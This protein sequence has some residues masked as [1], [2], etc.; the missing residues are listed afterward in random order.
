MCCPSVWLRAAVSLDGPQKTE[1]QMVSAHTGHPRMT[2]SRRQYVLTGMGRFR[3]FMKGI[4][5]DGVLLGRHPVCAF[6]IACAWVLALS[7]ALFPVQGKA[8][9]TDENAVT[10]AEDVFGTTVGHESIGIYD[11]TNVRGFSPK[12]AGNYRIDGLYFDS[13]GGLSSRVNDSET[14]HVGPSAQGYDFPAPTALLQ[15]FGRAKVFRL[16]SAISLCRCRSCA[17]SDA[18]RP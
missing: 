15:E 17:R 6:R 3:P 9:R 13:Q 1:Y 4:D 16:M 14:I 10:S 8:Q 7:S 12:T 11:A 18:L 5:Q 2:C